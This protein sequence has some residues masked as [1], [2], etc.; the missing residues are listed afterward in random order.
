MAKW[1]DVKR[2]FDWKVPGKRAWKNITPGVK[3][4]TDAQ[5]DYAEEHGHGTE[6]ERP[7]D[8]D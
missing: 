3:Y 7:A 2:R 5:A 8:A 6:T 1:M 4:L